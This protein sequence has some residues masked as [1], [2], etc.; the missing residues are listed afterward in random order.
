MTGTGFRADP[1]ALFDAAVKFQ[2]HR[3]WA[4]QILQPL[5]GQLGESSGMAG[6]DVAGQS[7]GQRYDGAA[8]PVA[9][10]LSRAGLGM[11]QIG[12]GP[13]GHGRQ[14]PRRRRGIGCLA[15]WRA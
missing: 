7:F 9:D 2:D 8:R 3:L 6:A 11:G 12:L 1:Q 5:A 15:P 13:P 14:L 10:G 4:N